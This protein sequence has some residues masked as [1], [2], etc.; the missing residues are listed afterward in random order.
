LDVIVAELSVDDEEE[1]SVVEVEAFAAAVDG[2]H[3]E[4]N[5]PDPDPL[6]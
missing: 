1:V 6:T 5:N 2:F 4:G 3:A